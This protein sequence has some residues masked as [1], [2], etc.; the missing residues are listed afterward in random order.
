MTSNARLGGVV[1]ALLLPLTVRFGLSVEWIWTA[2]ALGFVWSWRPSSHGHAL[3]MLFSALL[4]GA[5][6][7]FSMMTVPVTLGKVAFLNAL[8]QWGLRGS[9][10][11]PDPI[12]LLGC[13]LV[14]ASLW[15]SGWGTSIGALG[16]SLAQTEPFISWVGTS[17]LL[18]VVSSST[19]RSQVRQFCRE[20]A[21]LLLLLIAVYIPTG[22]DAVLAGTAKAGWTMRVSG[23]IGHANSWGMV[24][25]SWFSML[26]AGY[27]SGENRRERLIA[28]LLFVG[29][30][31]AVL[32]TM[33]RA[34]VMVMIGM[35]VFA[36]IQYR[37][38]RKVLLVAGVI[39]VAAAGAFVNGP[40]LFARM[41]SLL[42]PQQEIAQ[43][44]WSLNVR[45]RVAGFA[46]EAWREHFWFGCGAGQAVPLIETMSHQRLHVRPH[47]TYL[48]VLMETGLVGGIALGLVIG[49]CIHLIWRGRAG[50]S[51]PPLSFSKAWVPTLASFFLFGLFADLVG[52]PLFWFL[53][54]LFVSCAKPSVTAPS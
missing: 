30:T 25:V 38:N 50:F 41:A 12:L 21:I 8:I 5:E 35:I 7:V 29:V 49:R 44:F 42:D 36:L 53:L 13:S 51:S 18:I 14:L 34:A 26:L 15:M 2:A 47:N 31:V 46:L 1:F 43:G 23:P 27:M 4:C 3:L 40:G 52:F 10:R 24:L 17:V 16:P 45:G 20:A 22:L 28:S 9:L 6:G 19:E 11:K 37:T 33:S 39:A 48:L 32:Q 54:A